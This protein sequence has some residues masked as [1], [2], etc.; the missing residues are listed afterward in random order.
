M[1][2]IAVLGASGRMGR[3]VIAEVLSQASLQLVS[4]VSGPASP[5]LGV[6]A[7]VLTGLPPSGVAITTASKQAFSNADVVIDFS[8]PEALEN[9]LPL[10]AGLPLVS[11]TTGLSSSQWAQLEQHVQTAPQL[12]ATNFS[13][14]VNLLLHLVAEAAR[15]MPG[16]DVEIVESHHRLKQDAPSGTALSLAE[17]VAHAR[18][19]DLQSVIRHGREGRTGVRTAAEIGMHAVRGGD[20][21]GEHTVWLLGNGERLSLAHAASSRATF[22][23][24]AVRAA[25][26]LV[27]RNPGRYSMRQVLGL[28][29]TQEPQ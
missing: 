25:Q 10:L 21:V 7:G 27:G 19:L 23:S 8:L 3:L 11:G 17:S 13:T 18:G 16:L 12:H 29:R 15:A 24:G 9:A 2:R 28:D 14:G 4:A 26:W 20:V 22:A 1:T 6:D 5:A